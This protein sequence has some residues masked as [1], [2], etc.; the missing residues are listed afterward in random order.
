MVGVVDL[1]KINYF[2]IGGRYALWGGY[3]WTLGDGWA[4][5][6]T[7]VLYFTNKEIHSVFTMHFV[8]FHTSTVNNRFKWTELKFY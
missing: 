2:G 5:L 4:Q 3:W 8:V 6:G 7:M 1:S